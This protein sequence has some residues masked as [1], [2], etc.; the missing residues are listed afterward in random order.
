MSRIWQPW[1]VWA[2][3]AS[4]DHQT[5]RYVT[6]AGLEL[7]ESRYVADDLVKLITARA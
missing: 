6:E 5:E 3:G 2:Y 1:I 7:V 4:F